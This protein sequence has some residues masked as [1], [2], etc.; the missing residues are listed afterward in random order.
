MERLWRICQ[1]HL[2]ADTSRA[3]RKLPSSWKAETTTNFQV[4]TVYYAD[5]Y[6]FDADIYYIPINNNY[7]SQPCS[8]NVNDTCFINN[9]KATY[10]G[11][12]GEGTYAFQN[13]FGMNA[14]GLSRFANGSV[15]R[16]VAQWREVA[17]QR[18]V[19]DGGRGYLLP[20]WRLALRL[21]R[22]IYRPKPIFRHRQ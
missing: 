3:A 9:G 16:S 12:E 2:R 19:L 13:L 21:D 15:M 8:G 5:H 1:G 11:I 22:Q 6:T 7:I 20:G 4:G 17:T 14:E 18:A 10:Q